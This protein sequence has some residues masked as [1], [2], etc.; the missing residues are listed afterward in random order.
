MKLW[1]GQY[2]LDFEGTLLSNGTKVAVN[3]PDGLGHVKK[4]FLAAQVKTIGNIH[5]ISL[6]TRGCSGLANQK[7]D[8]PLT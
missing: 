2:G 4:S 8:H 5:H 7:K 3:H 1:Q 6:E